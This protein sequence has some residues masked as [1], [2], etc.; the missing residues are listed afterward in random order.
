VDRVR[1]FLGVS[2]LSRSACE[3]LDRAFTVDGWAGHDEVAVP[4][5]LRT[6]GLS[7]E[8]IGGDGEFVRPG[9]ENRFYTNSPTRPLLAPGTFVCPPRVPDSLD[10]PGKLYHPVK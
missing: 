1:A 5:I 9:N 10:Q 7:L 2:R 8:D 6:Y 4:T 3:T